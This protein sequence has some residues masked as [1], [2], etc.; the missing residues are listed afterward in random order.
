MVFHGP[1]NVGQLQLFYQ[2][3]HVTVETICSSQFNRMQSLETLEGHL[4]N[5]MI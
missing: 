3:P 1:D 5:V 2:L 4:E